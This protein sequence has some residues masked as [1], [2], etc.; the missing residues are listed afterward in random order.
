MTMWTDLTGV[1]F[2]VRTVDTHVGS[3]RITTRALQ[4]GEGFATEAGPARRP[5]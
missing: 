2:C 3:T 4:A 5:H 1:D